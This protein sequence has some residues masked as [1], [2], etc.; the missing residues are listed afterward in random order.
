MPGQAKPR[1]VKSVSQWNN[2]I[3]SFTIINTF[4]LFKVI[5]SVS[6]L[7]VP[8]S[9]CMKVFYLVVLMNF[10][11]PSTQDTRESQISI[12]KEWAPVCIR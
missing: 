8:H 6:P 4:S 9:L 5:P 11:E 1:Q 12:T 7:I 2:G 10:Y 3:K